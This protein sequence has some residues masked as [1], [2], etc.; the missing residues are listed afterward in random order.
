MFPYHTIQYKNEQSDF[1]YLAKKGLVT[2]VKIQG[3]I[4]RP[5]LRRNRKKII[6]QAHEE[7]ELQAYLEELEEQDPTQESATPE[8]SPISNMIPGPFLNNPHMPISDFKKG[9]ELYSFIKQPLFYKPPPKTKCESTISSDSVYMSSIPSLSMFFQQQPVLENLPNQ[10]SELEKSLPISD[11][12]VS[13]ESDIVPLLKPEPEIVSEPEIIPVTKQQLETTIEI[14]DDIIIDNPVKITRPVYTGPV[15]ELKTKLFGKSFCITNKNDDKESSENSAYNNLCNLPSCNLTELCEAVKQLEYQINSE[16][17]FYK[18][19]EIYND[20]TVTGMVNFT[21]SL[22][23]NGPVTIN[24][25]TTI[26]NSL[27]VTEDLTVLGTVY[28]SLN[29]IGPIT[30]Y[31]ETSVNNNLNVTGLASFNSGINMTTGVAT[32]SKLSVSGISQFDNAVTIDDSLNVIGASQ[33]YGFSTINNSMLIISNLTVSGTVFAASQEIANSTFKDIQVDG[34]AVISGSSILYGAVTINNNLNVTG[35]ATFNSGLTLTTGVATVSSLSVSGTSTFAGAVTINNSLN[36]T[37]AAT[38]NSGL[39]L[40]TGVAT[41]SSLNVSGTSTFAGDV[42]INNSLNVTGAATFNSGLTLTTGVATVSSLNVSGTSTFSSAV[43]INNS[44]NV[45]G[46]ATFNSGLT[47]TTGVARVSS[48]NVSGASTFSSAVT[49]NN[50]LNVTG[51][52]TF[53]SGLTLTTGVATVSSLNVNGASTFSSAVTINNSL[54]V[55]GAATFS[56]S[57]NVSGPITATI[58]QFSNAACF[59]QPCAY[60]FQY[61]QTTFAKNTSAQY[62]FGPSTPSSGVGISLTE[63]YNYEFE[64]YLPLYTNSTS[65]V[66]VSPSIGLGAGNGTFFGSAIFITG[67]FNYDTWNPSGLT[68][69]VSDTYTNYLPASTINIS[70]NPTTIAPTVSLSDPPYYYPCTVKGSLYVNSTGTFKPYFIINGLLNLP[71]YIMDNGAY[72]KIWNFGNSATQTNQS[73]GSWS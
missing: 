18:S 10:L 8:I 36:V 34:T 61:N 31:G 17:A 24:G 11:L 27:I 16:G 47:L 33:L 25:E 44:L 41:V 66:I 39:T 28:S 15:P 51:A 54:N 69:Y 71:Q 48:L 56:T 62:F 32:L 43:T 29:V 9:E 68:G 64:M 42:T 30:V 65:T 21:T 19:V 26:N 55:T 46:A 52:A 14:K 37:G 1:K 4:I 53:N 45:T 60:Y 50:S 72:I 2:P 57:L 49:I 22:N 23:V 13:I 3:N 7:P 5:K 73:S 35:A 67:F 63:G 59:L 6:K 38:F 20:L 58:P 70:S 40:T 12:S